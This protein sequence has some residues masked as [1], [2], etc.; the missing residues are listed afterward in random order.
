MKL[1]NIL[2]AIS[3]PVTVD[4]IPSDLGGSDRS[5][6]EQHREGYAV[7]DFRRVVSNRKK[8]APKPALRFLTARLVASLRDTGQGSENTVE[9]AN[10]LPHSYL[11]GVTAEYKTADASGNTFDESNTL[12]IQQDLLKESSRNIVFFRQLADGYWTLPVGFSQTTKGSQRVIR[13]TGKF[14]ASTTEWYERFSG[15]NVD[16]TNG[17]VKA[18]IVDSSLLSSVAATSNRKESIN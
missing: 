2:K 9:M 17:N 8:N 15:T 4:E 16:R 12:K 13:L 14:H 3:N 7:H 10:D 1:K 11:R 5:H 18:P 6:L